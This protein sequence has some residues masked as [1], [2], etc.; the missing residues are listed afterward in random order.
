MNM[1]IQ[2]EGTAKALDTCHRPWL[3]LGAV[4]TVLDRLVDGILRESP[5]HDRMDLGGEILCRGHPVPQRHGH[6]HYPLACRDPGDDALDQVC[7]SLGHPLARTRRTKPP[8]LAT[9]SQEHLVHA[10]ITATSQKAV[11]DNTAV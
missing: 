10:D 3:H 2:I 5:A 8:P 1:E 11:G 4:H 9:A 6:R 7:C